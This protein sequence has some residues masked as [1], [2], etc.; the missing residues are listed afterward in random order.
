L[1]GGLLIAAI[2]GLDS[3]ATMDMDTTVKGL[4][5]THES[6][7]K[8]FSEICSIPADDNITFSISHIT[9]IR[10]RDEYSG[11]R[12]HLIANYFPIAVDMKIDVT[13]GDKITPK[14]IK[15]EYKML[16]DPGSISIM[17]YNLETIL[18]EKL[19]TILSRSIANTRP[20]DF[21]DVF[22]LYKLK[23]DN[24]DTTILHKALIETA[25]KRGSDSVIWD[26]KEIISEINDD[27]Q[28][29]NFWKAYKE[30]FSYAKD[31]SFSAVCET[32]LHLMEMI[33]SQQI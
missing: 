10:E 11:L 28:M 7:Y 5:L 31:I 15:Y 22:I 16:F 1:K 32:I 21:Y 14:E 8:I 33:E 26:Y 17:A 9:D 13:T 29:Q 24:C 25:Q 27:S 19:E 12:V 18:A 23:L 6:M 2:I 4:P 30:E 3:R 20:R